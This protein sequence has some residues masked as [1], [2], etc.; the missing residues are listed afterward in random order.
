[1]QQGYFVHLM[2]DKEYDGYEVFIANQDG[3]KIKS[4]WFSDACE[5]PFLSALKQFKT[6]QRKILTNAE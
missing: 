6:Y 2:Y 1:M 5:E 3:E 4:E